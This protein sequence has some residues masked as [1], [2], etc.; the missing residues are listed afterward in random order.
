[1]AGEESDEELHIGPQVPMVDVRAA[2]AAQEQQEKDKKELEELLKFLGES[3]K[4]ERNGSEDSRAESCTDFC[5][6]VKR[7]MHAGVHKRAR[8]ANRER[9]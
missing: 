8:E 4:A 3:W 7:T 9:A 1:M 5:S 2:V 6:Y